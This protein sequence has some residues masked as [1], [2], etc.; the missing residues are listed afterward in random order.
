MERGREAK[1]TEICGR[2]RI[3]VLK[4]TWTLVWMKSGL[5][6]IEIVVL[7]LESGFETEMC[8]DARTA[9]YLTIYDADKKKDLSN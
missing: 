7:T 6:G 8:D 1:E 3:W 4:R 9:I 5:S 2:G